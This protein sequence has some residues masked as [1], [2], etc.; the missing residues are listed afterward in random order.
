MEKNM[1]NEMEAGILFLRAPE[2]GDL[3]GATGIPQDAQSVNPKPYALKT[4]DPRLTG[5]W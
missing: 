2:F 5:C 4:Q 3:F 1:E